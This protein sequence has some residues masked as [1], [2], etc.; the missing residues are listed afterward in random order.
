MIAGKEAVGRDK[1]LRASLR[2][3]GDHRE[4][5]SACILSH[6]RQRDHRNHRNLIHTR[7]EDPPVHSGVDRRF[8]HGVRLD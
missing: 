7:R 3:G 1:T 6:E 4:G 2:G 5:N 8:R